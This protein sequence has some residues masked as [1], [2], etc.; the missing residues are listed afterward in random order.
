MLKAAEFQHLNGF[1]SRKD[2]RVIVFN[3]YKG[4][5][6]G[7]RENLDNREVYDI[8]HILPRSKPEEFEELFPGLDTD[9]LLNLYLLCHKCNRGVGNFY[10]N[11]PAL[12]HRVYS[13]SGRMIKTRLHKVW[14]DDV[15]NSEAWE[16][17]LVHSI[18]V[19]WTEAYEQGVCYHTY[20]KLPLQILEKNLS[21]A[22]EKNGI[23]P[24]QNNEFF[25]LKYHILKALSHTAQPCI[26]TNEIDDIVLSFEVVYYDESE[27]LGGAR[28][29]VEEKFYERREV[30][31]TILGTKEKKSSKWLYLSGQLL[32]G[33]LPAEIFWSSEY[34]RTVKNFL[35]IYEWCKRLLLNKKCRAGKYIIAFD[36]PQI[37]D[38]LPWIVSPRS[39]KLEYLA[40]LFWETFS[41]QERTDFLAYAYVHNHELVPEMNTFVDAESIERFIKSPKCKNT[42]G[43][44]FI[45]LYK[46]VKSLRQKLRERLLRAQNQ[47]SIEMKRNA[48]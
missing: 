14:G 36:L 48:F 7:C 12:L 1:Y 30:N 34:E 8:G 4:I 20:H 44:Y 22:L 37:E 27:Q 31:T 15:I 35:S 25:L 18:A 11:N 24:P 2:C 5:C 23:A 10:V 43:T 3:L 21:I 9:N 39:P 6:Q 41:N 32:D 40:K 28:E 42:D 16:P 19:D 17:F 13:Y 46:Q 47:L 29:A 45:V 38:A 26:V 33:S